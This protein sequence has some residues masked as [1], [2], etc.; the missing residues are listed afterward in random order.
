MCD[1][2]FLAHNEWGNL[3]AIWIYNIISRAAVLPPQVTALAKT[4]GRPRGQICYT[5]IRT[6]N[7]SFSQTLK[8][9]AETS[10]LSLKVLSCQ[11]LYNPPYPPWARRYVFNIITDYRRT[12]MR[13]CA[14]TITIRMR[15]ELWHAFTN[16]HTK[17]AYYKIAM[18]SDALVRCLRF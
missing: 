8:T 13:R 9:S 7:L 12:A 5:Q 17:G 6:H 14:L 18:H 4:K 16:I 15:S 1:K 3:S 11:L 10:W 2:I